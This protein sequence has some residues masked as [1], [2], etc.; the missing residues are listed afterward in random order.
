MQKN[1]RGD[2]AASGKFLTYQSLEGHNT[3][4][5]HMPATK[6]EQ[7]RYNSEEDVPHL[8]RQCH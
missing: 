7:R 6:L 5:E 8:Y 4:G 1:V 3:G 2:V